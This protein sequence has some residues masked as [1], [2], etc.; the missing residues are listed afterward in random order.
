M[1]KMKLNTSQLPR[2]HS[3][4]IKM[5]SYGESITGELTAL[6]PNTSVYLVRASGAGA[7]AIK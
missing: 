6:M 7:A 2:V 3:I 5:G 4:R 1:C